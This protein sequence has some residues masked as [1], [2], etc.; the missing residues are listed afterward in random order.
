[1]S[2]VRCVVSC[3]IDVYAGYAGRARDVVKELI[4]VK[5]DWDIS[6]LSQ[7]WGD[8]R[9]GY[10]AEHKEYEL[11]S[12][13]VDAIQEQP[14]VWIQITV[15]DEFQPVGKFNIGMTAA[16]ETN[17]SS[18]EWIRGCN[19]MDLVLTSSEHGKH[20]L[21]DSRWT[22]NDTGENVFVKKPVEVLFEGLDTGKYHSLDKSFKSPI[23]K[24]LKNSWNF[25]CVGHWM[26]G[27]FG[28]DRKNIA[29]TIRT[30]LEAFKDKEGQVPG[31]VLKTSQAVSSIL[32][33]DTILK[34]IQEVQNSVQYKKSLPN[35]YLLHGDLT[36]AEM[37]EV[38]NDSRIKA[39]ALL[40]KG[41]GF[42]RPFLEFAATGKPIITTAWSGHL[43]FLKPEY[44][45][46]VGGKLE[47]VHRSA[48]QP[49]MILP[50][51]SWFTP[52]DRD[53]VEAFKI[54]FQ[55]YPVWKA[56]AEK[57][58][59]IINTNWTIASMGEKLKSI[60]DEHVPD[61]PERVGLQLPGLQNLV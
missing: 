44:T 28:Q 1:M 40:T 6:I 45:A 5:P 8:C 37:N 39:M 46:L 22:M 30:F 47:K 48:V 35:I 17:L 51:A 53:S 56:K 20:S 33:R 60:L 21:V 23:L 42:G 52:D 59:E 36:D 26:R 12:H 58:A 54:V 14:D 27:D 18:V 49:G 50:E 9:F 13:I 41:E 61:F 38:Y 57:Q 11:M 43:D 29:Y 16:M 25:L 31:L 32:D 7:R 55:D 15:P 10:L 34:K 24:D 3:P 2:K 19:R 4:R